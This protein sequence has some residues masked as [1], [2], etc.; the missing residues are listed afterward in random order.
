MLGMFKKIS[1]DGAMTP[2]LKEEKEPVT[3]KTPKEKKVKKKGFFGRMF[4]KKKKNEKE[5]E[6]IEEEPVLSP[7]L[8]KLNQVISDEK[9]L[10]NGGLSHDKQTEKDQNNTD[11][12]KLNDI[13][14]QMEFCDN[15]NSPEMKDR[16]KGL[17]F[18]AEVYYCIGL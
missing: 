14:E 11:I 16:M 8:I 12:A 1:S 13:M 6:H 2:K 9:E 4:S 7:Y 17:L 3:A 10:M 5:E 15:Q 18:K